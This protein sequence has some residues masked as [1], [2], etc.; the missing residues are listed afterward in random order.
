VGD[1]YG[2]WTEKHSLASDI[3]FLYFVDLG[4]DSLTTEYAG[5]ALEERRLVFD[6]T[7][8]YCAD[9]LASAQERLM[10]GSVGKRKGRRTRKSVGV[11]ER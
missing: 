7:S 11:R 5:G 10:V 3:S 9:R 4:T 8:I 6:W 2:R 1:G